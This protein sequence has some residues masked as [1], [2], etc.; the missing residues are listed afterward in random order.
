[1]LKMSLCRLR[2]PAI[3]VC[4]E[5]RIAAYLEELYQF[6]FTWKCESVCREKVQCRVSSC[7]AGNPGRTSIT[8]QSACTIKDMQHNGTSSAPKRGLTFP[9]SGGAGQD[10]DPI[11]VR[12]H[13]AHR[14]NDR[15]CEQK[16]VV[17]AGTPCEGIEVR[18]A[19]LLKS[20]NG[21]REMGFV[22][23]VS[24]IREKV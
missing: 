14:S 7:N 24:T 12:V 1:M 21:R 4:E 5:A 23:S 15:D 6:L 8:Q 3:V 19:L 16:N 17:V 9:F 2:S 18:D 10:L 20:P 11:F 13:R 22:V